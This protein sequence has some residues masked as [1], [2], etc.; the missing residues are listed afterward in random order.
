MSGN[1]L[2]LETGCLRCDFQSGLLSSVP[3]KGTY[4]LAQ[5]CDMLD[6]FIHCI[7]A[8]EETLFSIAKTDKPVPSH[9]G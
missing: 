1:S 5:D 4:S 7:Q 6:F 9:L 8:C 3:R 2:E